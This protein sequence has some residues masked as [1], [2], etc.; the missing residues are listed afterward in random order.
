[1]EKFMKLQ[2]TSVIKFSTLIQNLQSFAGTCF[3][4]RSDYD[5]NPKKPC[6]Y[7]HVNKVFDISWNELLEKAGIPIK[8]RP[9]FPITSGRKPKDVSKNKIITCLQCDGLFESID[10]RINRICGKC[11]NLEGIEDL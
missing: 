11:K 8:H 7:S 3:L 9:S 5:N 1:M 6:S 2:G 4:T 10:P